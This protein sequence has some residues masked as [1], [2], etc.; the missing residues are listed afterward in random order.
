VLGAAGF[1]V[2]WWAFHGGVW[3]KT[4]GFVGLLVVIATAALVLLSGRR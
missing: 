1:L 2:T 3:A 4:F